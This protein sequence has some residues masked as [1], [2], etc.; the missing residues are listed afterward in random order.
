MNRTSIWF[1]IP[2]K[3]SKLLP[4]SILDEYDYKIISLLTKISQKQLDKEIINIMLSLSIKETIR[5]I[6]KGVAHLQNNNENNL[7][8]IKIKEMSQILR[9]IYEQV[10]DYIF[11]INQS[12][13]DQKEFFT[14][15][16]IYIEKQ[17]VILYQ[18]STNVVFSKKRIST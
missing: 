2:G 5:L 17:Q 6:G 1:V 9:T 11:T 10:S 15:I 12:N 16:K 3:I 18:I 14:L 7:Y 8:P 13:K 4:L